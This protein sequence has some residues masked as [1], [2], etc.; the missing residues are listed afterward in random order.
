MVPEQTTGPWTSQANVVAAGGWDA[1]FGPGM[2]PS[3]PTG[4]ARI[5][6]RRADR[7]SAGMADGPE[8][9]VEGVG[10]VITASPANSPFRRA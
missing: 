9:S 1:A 7:L 3:T 6:L 5:S 10:L 4:A 8:I 2:P